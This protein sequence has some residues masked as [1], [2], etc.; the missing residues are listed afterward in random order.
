MDKLSIH[1]TIEAYLNDTL[2]EADRQ[3]FEK[4]LEESPNLQMELAI[5]RDL[6][7]LLK[8]EQSVSDFEAILKEEGENHDY[9]ETEKK[10]DIRA[11]R[12]GWMAVAALVLFGFLYVAYIN[13]SS[14][15]PDYDSLFAAYFEP[16]AMTDIDRNDPSALDSL[17]RLG[18]QAYLSKDFGKALQHFTS[19][20]VGEGVK[21]EWAFY[22]GVSWMSIPN[23]DALRALESFKPVRETEGHIL[24]QSAFW[25]SG[26]AE[27]DIGDVDAARRY[28]EKVVSLPG[29]YSQRAQSLLKKID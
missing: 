9:H 26:L 22:T 1:E 6:Q 20:G 4:Q 5:H 16:A 2:S 12:V 19:I 3:A 18:V 21:L 10:I 11:N 8:N 17:E 23:S 7:G 25:Y 14:A 24:Q 15:E 28:L 27:L 13:I 29:K